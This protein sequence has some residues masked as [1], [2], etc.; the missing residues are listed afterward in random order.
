MHQKPG[1]GFGRRFLAFAGLVGAIV[2]GLAVSVGVG[3]AAS[4]ATTTSSTTTA[5]STT[6]KNTAPPTISG[7]PQVGQT[8][9]A[10]DGSWSS[11]TKLTYTYQW[12]RCDQN[13]GSCATISGA[14]AKTYTLKSV[15]SG[16]TLRVAV[17]AHNSSSEATATSV[18]TAVV[19]AVPTPAPTGCPHTTQSTQAVDVAQVSAPARLQVDQ[20]Q[21]PGTIRL[22]M[23]SFSVRFHVSDTCGQPVQGAKVYATAVPFN[24]V[25]IPAEQTT[26]ANGWV[27]LNF[28]RMAGFPAARNQQLMVMFVRAT[29]PGENALA[30]ISTRRLISLPVSLHG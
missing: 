30:G 8:L 13:G 2:A 20:F 12:S 9:T 3:S 1:P 29:K 25:T 22:N 14:T 11:P 15:D 21:G 26:D 6:P 19:T 23:S 27:T 17:T 10:N 28:N 16:N 4:T 24:Q 7:Q 5:A 18:P